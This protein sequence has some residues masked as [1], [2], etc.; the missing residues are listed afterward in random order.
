MVDITERVR[1]IR[2]M[3]DDGN[4]FCINRG[5]QYGKHIVNIVGGIK[6]AHAVTAEHIGDRDGEEQAGQLHE[7]RGDREDERT[8]KKGAFAVGCFQNRYLLFL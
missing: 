7:R 2:A 3:V 6:I 4:Y 5:R 8:L 1:Q